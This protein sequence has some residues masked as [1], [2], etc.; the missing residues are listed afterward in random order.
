ML[1]SLLFPINSTFFKSVL[2]ADLSPA[3]A[4]RGILPRQLIH[5][6]VEVSPEAVF[7]GTAI[8]S[9]A[10]TLGETSLRHRLRNHEL[11]CSEESDQVGID[12]PKIQKQGKT[13]LYSYPSIYQKR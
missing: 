4:Q 1:P 6:F 10:G 13:L 9:E 11:A 12:A 3:A 2:L 8:L 5:L 7:A